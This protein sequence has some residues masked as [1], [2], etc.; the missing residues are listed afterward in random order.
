[1]SDITLSIIIVSYN[2]AKL[3]S[4]AINSI[5]DELRENETLLQKTEIVVIDNHSSDNSTSVIKKIISK[6]HGLIN[7]ILIENKSNLG[8]AKANNIG[9]KKAKG[10]YILLLNSD[11]QVTNGALTQLVNSFESH[12]LDGTTSTLSS[13]K[14][15][16]DH[17][18]ILSATLINPDGSYQAQGGSLPSLFSL[19]TQMFFLDDLPIIGQ[20]LPTIQETGKAARY[21]QLLEHQLT[22]RLFQK[23]WVA[24]TAMMIRKQLILD[25]GYLDENIFMYGEDIEYCIRAKKHH[26]DIAIDPLATVF[27]YGSASSSSQSAIL[28]EIK[29]YQ[30]LWAKHQPHWQRRFFKLIL[31]FGI[32]VRICLFGSFFYNKDKLKT[33]QKALTLI[34]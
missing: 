7:C 8:F 26:W 1:M 5:L 23:G 28:G 4:L 22:N 32:L 24:G 3:T 30:Y 31:L 21:K 9:I 29:G 6:N 2:T 34:D 25:I 13:Q 17:L 33:Y 11:A 16:L 19:F 18:G 27:H 12:P 14:G 10:E 15:R 20:L